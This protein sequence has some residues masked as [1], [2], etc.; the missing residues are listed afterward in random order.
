MNWRLGHRPFN[1]HVVASAT[2]IAVLAL[3]TLGIPCTLG[4]LTPSHEPAAPSIAPSDT[5]LVPCPALDP[6]RVVRL[7]LSAGEQAALRGACD[8]IAASR[9]AEVTLSFVD[10]QGA[11]IRGPVQLEQV[12]H[13][14]R[15]GGHP[16]EAAAGTLT[17]TES[18]TY[19]VAFLGI[20]NHAVWGVPW[21][22]LEPTRGSLRRDLVDRALELT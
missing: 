5:S 1:A 2:A 7:E 19:D 20:F 13:L 12:R 16:N 21:R 8:R 22:T 3:G 14:F 15:F 10:V 4:T 6:E 18:A 9:R 11:P 17:A